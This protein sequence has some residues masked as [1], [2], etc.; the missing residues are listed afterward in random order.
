MRRHCSSYYTKTMNQT[1]TIEI[2]DTAALRLLRDL[3]ALSLIRFTPETASES[4][5]VTARLNEVYAR[6]DSSLDPGLMLAQAEAIAGE[7][8]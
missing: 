4:D 8:W 1:V 7:D 3:A 5:I 2:V 6:E